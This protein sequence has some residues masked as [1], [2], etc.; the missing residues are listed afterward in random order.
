MSDGICANCTMYMYSTVLCNIPKVLTL[1]EVAQCY[2]KAFTDIA[3]TGS[4]V[5]FLMSF[6]VVFLGTKVILIERERIQKFQK[7]IFSWYRL[8]KV[9][10]IY[11]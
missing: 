4:A 7:N 6:V 9:K 2:R 11:I 5:N 1:H 10:F 3:A 8:L